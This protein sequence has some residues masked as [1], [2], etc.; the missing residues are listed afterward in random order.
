MKKI[1]LLFITIVN[2]SFAQIGNSPYPVIFVHGLNSDDRTWNSTV[3]QLSASWNLSA[4]HTLSAVLNARGGD[5]TNYIQDVVIPL[6]DANGNIVNSITNSSIYTINFGNFWNRNNTDPRIIIYNN[7]TPGSNQNPSNQS[8]IYKQGFVL[9][10]L[11]DSVL[12]VT[13]AAKVI[14]AGHSMG[15]LA[16]RE[17]LQRTESGIHKWWVDPNDNISG[18]KVAKV[19][20]IGTPHIGT[21]VSIPISGIDFKSEAIR[22][23]RNS[24]TSNGSDAAYLFGN[25]EPAVPSSYYNKD[26]NCNGV[27]TDTI[28]GLDSNSSDNSTMPLPLNILYT[29]IMSNYLGLGTDLAVAYSSQAIYNDSA[30]VPLGVTDTLRTN[31]NHIQETGDTRSMI[32]GLDEPD[33]KSFAYDISFSKLYS[34]FITLQSNSQTSDSDYYKLKTLSGGKI[35][36]NLKSVNSG[37]TN[38]SLLSGNGILLITKNITSSPDSITYISTQG[39]CFIRIAGNSNQNPNLN[40]YNFTAN[41]IPASA[42][43]LNLGI[44][45]MW[46]GI[47]QVQDTVK[48]F[49]ANNS[50]P[51]NVSDSAIVK[52]NSSGNAVANFIH[53]SGG[54]YYIKILHRNAIE[55]W[56]SSPVIINNGSTANYDFTLAQSQAFGNNQIL[57]SGRWCIFS[58]DVNHD[59]IID[60]SD[61]SLVDNDV[62]SL[63]SGYV[64]TDLTGDLLVDVTDASIT[65][66][67]GFNFVTVIKP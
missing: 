33:N 57:K 20:T 34:G 15:G 4:N 32:R 50:S 37:V 63:T 1:F 10:I 3:T 25:F 51:F 16:I 24:F 9:K 21:D 38:I 2:I 30:F 55:T 66:N 28:T 31:K 27:I 44:E 12:R 5:T 48:I 8:A 29:W 64:N 17:Y 53:T 52:L 19:I 18:H 45:G 22:D 43:N 60:V 39:D 26:I 36:V 62:F 40:S 11:I 49:L 7:S 13:G 59:G 58:G 61:Q 35:T 65:D 47:A 67:N 42:L 56:S 46:D 14:L 6:L 41:I 54:N 23:M